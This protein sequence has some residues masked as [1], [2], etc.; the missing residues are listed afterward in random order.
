MPF[1]GG[2]WREKGTNY[3]GKNRWVIGGGRKVRVVTWTEGKI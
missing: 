1:L 2:V 3:P